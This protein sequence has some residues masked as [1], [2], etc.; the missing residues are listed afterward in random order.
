[1][2]AIWF[3]TCHGDPSLRALWLRE[4]LDAVLAGEEQARG[5]ATPV[6]CSF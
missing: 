3:R 5:V 2:T 4:A 1:V 6:A